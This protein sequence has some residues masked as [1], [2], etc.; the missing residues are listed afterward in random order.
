MV[1]GGCFAIAFVTLAAAAPQNPQARPPTEAQQRPVF[2]GGTHFVR[3]DAYPTSKDGR[4]IEGLKAEDFEIAEDGKPQTIE[5]FDYISFPTFTAEAERHDPESQRAG[6]DLAADPRYRVFVIVV[7]MAFGASH[8]GA[9][10][11]T[12]GD[13]GYI[14]APLVNFLDRVLGPQDLYGFLTSRNTAK[15]LVLGQRTVSV[16]AQIEDLFRSSAVDQDE[17]DDLDGCEKGAPLKERYRLDQTYT[18]LETLVTQLGR[19]GTS[20]RTLSS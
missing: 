16:K 7:D 19:C 2:R 14:Q 15:D 6:F 5:S 8:A 4:I 3:V 10:V 18:A 1:R 13:L 11:P 20:G 9:L 12:T 17:A